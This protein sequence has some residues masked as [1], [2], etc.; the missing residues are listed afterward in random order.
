MSLLVDTSVWSL[1]LR[2]ES[3][4]DL[5]EVGALIRALE[6]GDAVFT[7]GLVLQEL[8]HGF[9]GTRGRDS[10]A[11]RFGALPFVVPHWGD[12]IEAAELPKG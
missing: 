10:I 4:P 8:L 5:P 9:S 7:T 2:R 1:A 6:G 11:E 12:P 3:P